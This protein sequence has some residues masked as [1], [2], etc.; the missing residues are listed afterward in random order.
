[1]IFLKMKII[2]FENKDRKK[3]GEDGTIILALTKPLL[4]LLYHPNTIIKLEEKII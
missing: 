3:H 1:M 4:W 2:D